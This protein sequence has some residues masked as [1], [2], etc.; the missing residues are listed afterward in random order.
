MVNIYNEIFCNK[1]FYRHP[2]LSEK[3]NAPK[4][5]PTLSFDLDLNQDLGILLDAS[6]PGNRYEFL[7]VLAMTISMS[8]SDAV[9]M[10]AKQHPNV[11]IESLKY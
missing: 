11:N 3:H 4:L 10:T 5:L 6:M 9:R 8:N 7:S 2:T 1:E